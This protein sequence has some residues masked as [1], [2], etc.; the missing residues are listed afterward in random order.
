ML[1]GCKVISPSETKR[2]NGGKNGML[3]IKPKT[4][5]EHTN[6]VTIKPKS[7]LRYLFH[8]ALQMLGCYKSYSYF[9][10][11]SFSFLSMRLN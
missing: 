2:E 11:F 6:Y 1:G 5:K 10:F 8:P 7:L 3:T 4:F 9:F